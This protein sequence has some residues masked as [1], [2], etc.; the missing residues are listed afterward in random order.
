MDST[1]YQV[2][3]QVEDTHWWY[4]GMAEITCTV[5]DRWYN[6]PGNIRILDA[7]CGTGGMMANHLSRFGCVVGCDL[8]PIALNYCIRR[9]ST[10]LSR[11]DITALPFQANSF[12]LV[13]SFDVLSDGRVKDDRLALSAIKKV[14]S[15]GGRL[16]LRLPAY[17]WL[18]GHHDRAVLTSRRYISHQVKRLLEN[19]EFQVEYIT[20]ANMFL[21]PVI[22]M[23]RLTEKVFYQKGKK[24]D[25]FITAGQFNRIFK[26]LLSI[27]ARILRRNQLPFGLT[28]LAVARTA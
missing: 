20:Y 8:S 18:S 9:K 19:A 27:E 15:P 17:P 26:F 7:G 11:A 25:L 23:K 1:E 10:H 5:L 24:S 6:R 4:T 14:L 12:D 2:M 13:T 3:Y 28:V 21:F 22:M 16:L